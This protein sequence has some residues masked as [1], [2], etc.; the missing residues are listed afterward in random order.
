MTLGR[1][2][3]LVTVA[4]DAPKEMF[5]EDAVPLYLIVQ[6]DNGTIKIGSLKYQVIELYLVI[7]MEKEQI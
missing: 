1:K 4:A 7:M 3:V 6:D 5:T 2:Q